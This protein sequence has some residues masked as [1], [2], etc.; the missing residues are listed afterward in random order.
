M[1]NCS[2][3]AI[4]FPIDL[5]VVR[6]NS[7]PMWALNSNW[8]QIN[9]L[10]TSKALLYLTVKGLMLISCQQLH[11]NLSLNEY[12]LSI[13]SKFTS[14]NI[15]ISRHFSH[16]DYLLVTEICQKIP[17]IKSQSVP[18]SQRIVLWLAA[19]VLFSYL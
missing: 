9:T 3:A 19:I 5:E 12:T 16:S 6:Q 2:Q 11:S 7:L 10:S 13:C 8:L 4:M 17:K 18:E 15:D 14:L 1:A